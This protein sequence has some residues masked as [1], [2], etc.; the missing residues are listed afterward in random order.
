MNKQIEDLQCDGLKIIQDKDGYSFTSDAVLLANYLKAN[1]G[2]NVVE[3]CSGSA[4]ISIL[5]T[6]KTR[7]KYFYCFELQKNLSEISEESVKLNNI[8][9]ITIYNKDIL[10][11]PKVLQGKVIDVVVV[12]PPYYSTGIPS[13]NQSIAM[14]T[15]EIS[16]NLK[17]VAE[18]AGK[19]LKFGGRFYM[20]HLAE[21]FAE[22][23]SE[24]IK[25]K[26]QPK[27][28]TFVRP[29]PNKEYN[30]VLIS[31]T[32]GGKV[33]LKYSE[34]IIQDEN[35]NPTKEILKMYNKKLT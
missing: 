25:N 29:T 16:T 33:G 2:E 28:V 27:Q 14:A 26:L 3:L 8:K 7:A 18:I 5:A 24:L 32:K 30:L 12:N 20:V 35:G 9:N 11:A 34:L 21:R 23:C 15:H 17:S 1:A 6:K 19:L 10:H 31:A 22:I 13:E 4:V